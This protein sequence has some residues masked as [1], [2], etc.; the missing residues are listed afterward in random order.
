M[1]SVLTWEVFLCTQ[2]GYDRLKERPK[3]PQRVLCEGKPDVSPGSDNF[4]VTMKYACGG[5]SELHTRPVLFPRLPTLLL[6]L[7]GLRPLSGP[8]EPLQDYGYRG[9]LKLDVARVAI[10]TVCRAYSARSHWE[11]A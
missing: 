7:V 4:N 8:L 3:G 1:V 9:Y 5:R 11:T 2:N 6:F 10:L